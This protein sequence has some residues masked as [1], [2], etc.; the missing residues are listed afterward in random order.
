MATNSLL[1]RKVYQ[2]GKRKTV[3]NIFYWSL[4]LLLL[5]DSLLGQ[6]KSLLTLLY[7]KPVIY[8]HLVCLYNCC[9]IQVVSET[10]QMF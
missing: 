6:H 8:D 5:W 3:L 10:S 4:L 7:T 1:V 9:L 2:Y